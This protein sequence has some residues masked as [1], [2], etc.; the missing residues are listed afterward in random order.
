MSKTYNLAVLPGDG[1]GPEVMAEALR[2]L[3]NRERMRR[4]HQ[5]V[6]ILHGREDTLLPPS[7]SQEL[8]DACPSASKQLHVI[9]FAT[10]NSLL[11][12]GFETYFQVLGELVAEARRGTG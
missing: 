7:H 2:V 3:D 12:V 11:S 4:V 10:H 5:P 1:I 9:P 6:R 8:M